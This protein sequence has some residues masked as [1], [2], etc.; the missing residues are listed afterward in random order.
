MLLSLLAIIGVLLGVK[1]LK[2]VQ[3]AVERLFGRTA[4][5]RFVQGIAVLTA[6]GIYL[7][8]VLRWNSWTVIHHPEVIVDADR[9]EPGRP[10]RLVLALCATVV[11]TIG[12]LVAYRVLAGPRRRCAWRGPR[13]VARHAE[14]GAAGRPQPLCVIARSGW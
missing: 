1:S 3:G 8:R 11:F 6:V 12:F 13:A 2:L 10:G 14:T 5:W 4:G 7:G 9:A